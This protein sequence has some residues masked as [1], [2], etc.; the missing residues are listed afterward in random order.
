LPKKYG[1]WFLGLNDENGFEIEKG[2]NVR[3]N[4]V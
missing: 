3:K 1:G 4:E 2:L